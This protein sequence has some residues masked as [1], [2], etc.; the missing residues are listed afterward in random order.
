M[1]LAPSRGGESGSF[2]YKGDREGGVYAPTSVG[3]RMPLT[4]QTNYEA[5]GKWCH[6]RGCS[7][8]LTSSSQP[9]SLVPI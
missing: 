2:V 3:R 8:T 5:F 9:T 4:W 1:W 6:E 7:V